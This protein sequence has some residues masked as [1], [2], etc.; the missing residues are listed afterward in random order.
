M[1][2][3]FTIFICLVFLGFFGQT[4]EHLKQ[5]ERKFEQAEKQFDIGNYS[6]A[7]FKIK[8]LSKKQK[9]KKYALYTIPINQAFEAKC[10]EAM[11]K[12]NE[13]NALLLQAD[14]AFLT[15]KPYP[16][17]THLSFG[18][19]Q[20]AL[21]YLMQDNTLKAN[22]HLG[23]AAKSY[24]ERRIQD[25]P[26]EAEL[27]FTQLKILYHQQNLVLGQKKAFE[28]I[29]KQRII[30]K[31]KEVYFNE[32]SGRK[33][34]R[35]VPK[36]EYKDR[37][38]RLAEIQVI[39]ANFNRIE[40]NY[41]RADTL[42]HRNENEF[43][44]L[45]NKRERAALFNQFGS[46][47]NKID[48]DYIEEGLALLSKTKRK[49]AKRLKYHIPNTF[50]YDVSK[51]QIEAYLLADDLSGYQNA[52]KQYERETYK[53][54]GSSSA[55]LLDVKRFSIDALIAKGK[56]RKAYDASLELVKEVEI[57]VP[58][59]HALKILFYQ[60]LYQV[61]LINYNYD[62]ARKAL[63]KTAEL[64][65][66]NYGNHCLAFKVTLL[67][68][69]YLEAYYANN[70]SK[71]DSLYEQNFNAVMQH[72][73]HP[74]HKDYIKQLNARARLYIA[75]EEFI[76]AENLLNRALKITE[77]KYGGE[78]V[79]FAYQLTEIADL[80]MKKGAYKDAQTSLELAITALDNFY[81]RKTF[82]YL[83]SLKFLGEL[84]L[85]NGELDLAKVTLEK[86]QKISSKLSD[87]E[88][89]Y[90]LQSA[91]ELGELYIASGRYSE[92]EKLLEKS[93]SIL[94]SS[95]PKNHFKLGEPYKQLG[96]LYY[97]QGE[98][99]KAEQATQN[100]LFCIE[101]NL[102]DSSSI[103]IELLIQLADIQIALGNFTKAE[104][105]LS[106]AEIKVEKSQTQDP[107]LIYLV[108]YKLSKFS[109]EQ[110]IEEKQAIV[111]LEKIT[112]LTSKEFSKNHPKYAEALSL[113]ARFKESL[114][115]YA[116]AQLLYDTALSI[117][118]ET[119]NNQHLTVGNTW[120]NKAKAFY[121]QSN[122]DQALECIEQALAI[123]KHAFD[124]KNINYINALSLKGKCYYAKKDYQNAS[125]TIKTTTENYL[126]FVNKFFPYLS[127]NEKHDYWRSIK[128]E[129]EFWN[130]IAL[131]T[132]NTKP[133]NLITMYNYQLATKSLLLNSSKKVKE[134]IANS[135]DIDL[136]KNYDDWVIKKE[137][138]ASSIGLST[139]QLKNK[140]ININQIEKEINDL[141][142]LL[143]EQSEGFAKSIDQKQ[144]TTKEISKNLADNE[145]AVEIIQFRY[146]NT[147]FTDSIIYAALVITQN[148]PKP[149]AKFLGNG[150][151]LDGKYYRYFKNAVTKTV[152]DRYSYN[153]YWEPIKELVAE[154][155]TIYLS[156]DGVYNQ[157]NLELLKDSTGTYLID[158]YTF[159][160]LSNTKDIALRTEMASSSSF[161]GNSA[162]LFGNPSFTSAIDEGVLEPLPGAQLE[163]E[164]ID[165]LLIDNNWATE[166]YIADRSTEEFL[167]RAESPRV[168]HIATH[169]I[170]TE[171][172]ESNHSDKEEILEKN[173]LLRA[174]LLL[175][176]SD[177]LYATNNPL[178]YNKADGI[179]TAYEAMNLRLD[180]TELVV[181]SACETGVGET[182]IGEGVY[183]LQRAF[184][185]AGA[186]NVIMSLFKVDDDVTRELMELFYHEWLTTGN[187]RS[188]FIHAKQTIKEKYKDPIHWGS[189]VLIGLD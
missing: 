96:K 4:Q 12:V 126:E 3:R 43:K 113:Q 120:E 102:S 133:E 147:T 158:K 170:F 153:M 110:G 6:S 184:L 127:E 24:Y 129:F 164:Q 50:Y 54:F 18:H 171:L 143:S 179:L 123:Y 51:A 60:Q 47:Q 101:D 55:Y 17:L 57:K 103:S 95:Y 79:P 181:L 94:S 166:L 91:S 130:S 72:A 111:Y 33:E 73:W 145:A 186:N 49:Y 144:F 140:N 180:F 39:K 141:E 68:L 90:Q 27:R 41:I 159:Y 53:S 182:M 22:D 165:S 52:V 83:N 116:E 63:E 64:E 114:G 167:K 136:I 125:K 45:I 188:A 176:Y 138:Y 112:S 36:Q 122:Y 115:M 152:D 1:T 189:F 146:F 88:L 5:W 150:S 30:T 31:K 34:H 89:G 58:F 105:L 137:L 9:Q 121:L 8:A 75:Q 56:F 10:L 81:G 97:L 157:I 65:R 183:G 149:A 77:E 19:Q 174:G 132:A 134:R 69:A 178:E 37:L 59:Q 44:E 40:G 87:L 13:A 100:A 38:N 28:L 25:L 124:K 117:Y 61:A 155:S 62:L 11:G 32:K 172:S 187:K 29:Q 71:A 99:T 16:S 108:Y 131:H 128:N 156:P 161:F 104:E 74:H 82:A 118:T 148:N 2:A 23:I 177:S 175:A 15:F 185:V 48:N 80:S 107:Q 160:T 93:V 78:S 70:F 173:P 109:I 67:E 21:A 169:G 42:Y 98:F 142:Q 84:Y 163:V 20:F 162:L 168:L 151:E 106:K 154:A 76:P 135:G 14:S 66:Y 139:S 86:A 26:Y 119:Y 85:I 7:Y 92:A 35:F 46:A